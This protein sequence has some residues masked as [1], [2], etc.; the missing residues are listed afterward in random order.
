MHRPDETIAALATAPGEGALA[1]LRISGPQARELL[2]GMIRPADPPLCFQPRRLE[3]VFLLDSD[4][5]PLDEVLAAWMPGPHSYTGED[6][7]EI[8]THGGAATVRAV[9]SELERRGCRPA[10]PGEFTYRAFLSGRMDLVQAEAVAELVRSRSERARELALT[11]LQGGLSR[12]F[13]A[14]RGK[15]LVL[16][17]D[18]EAGIDFVEEDIDLLPREEL[19]RGLDELRQEL[20][21]LLTGAGEGRLI[22]EGVRVV[23]AGEPNVGKSSL[24]NALLE[25]ERAIVTASP[26]TTRDVISESWVQRGI[27]FHLQDTAGL[28]EARGEAERKGVERSESALR[29]ALLT[30]WV[31]DGAREPSPS[32]RRRWRE[33]RPERDLLLVNKSDLPEYDMD[34][35]RALSPEGLEVLAVSA[36]QGDGIA[37]L[38]EMLHELAMGSGQEDA[39][40][41]GAVNRRQ[42][43][44]LL[45][46]QRSLAPLESGDVAQLESELLARQLREALAEL[47]ELTGDR[48]GERVLEEIFAGFC[49][50]K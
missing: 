31:T 49:V 35:A 36:L 2:L 40:L 28:R 48:I 3:H 34:R 11:Q 26:G 1:V 47:E 46:A 12:R 8:S 44:R 29:E 16:L 32:E 14:L 33:L 21:E 42:E 18:L 15:L 24:F 43:A 37:E 38:R 39:K 9:L 19:Q 23:L 22:R 50:G 17:R 25:S 7:V 10:F 41:E 27:V 6:V 30:I 5:R 45:A 20:G 13:S 4:G